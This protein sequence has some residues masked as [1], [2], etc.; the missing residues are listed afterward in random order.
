GG[1]GTRLWPLS[2]GLYPKQFLNLDD[3]SSM[4]E[5]TINRLEGLDVS[6]PLII[7]NEQH[8]FIVAEQLRTLKKLNRNILLEPI[9]KN[10][11]PALALA[12]LYN[13]NFN[14]NSLLLVLA[15]DHVIN[16]NQSFVTSI[17]KAIPYAIEGKLVTFG[18]EP[19]KPETG[20][21]YIKKGNECSSIAIGDGYHVERFVEK[22][23]F[24]SACDYISSGEYLWN[25]GMFLFEPHKYLSELR[26]YQPDIYNACVDAFKYDLIDNDFIRVDP[27]SFSQS[28][29]LSVDYAVMEKT[30]DAVVVPMNAEWSD[31]GSWAALWEISNKD[32][33]GN[34]LHGDVISLSTK[35]SYIYS[36]SELV[37][38]IGIENLAIVQTKDAILVSNL[39]STQDV[40]KLVEILQLNGRTEHY[41]H[42]ER[43]R[44]W[45]KSDTIDTGDSYQVKM[46]TIM[47]RENL[48]MQ[49][50]YKRAEHWVVLSGCAKIVIDGFE[51]ILNENESVHIPV[52][53]KHYLENIGDT[54]L[55]VIEIRSGSYLEEDD[56]IRFSDNDGYV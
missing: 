56:I 21:G 24:S 46:L 40:K 50:H 31:V 12:A 23:N 28:P 30:S 7:C 10:T 41:V 52:G 36:E 1:N 33:D 22:P 17:K 5:K 47:P 8:R 53:V 2:R 16:D 13:I 11:A 9:G 20:Y 18:I 55:R 6:L 44:P 49:V 37:T 51:S 19:T 25:S 3:T 15:A 54:P 29:S 48:S 43:Y 32:D 14:S 42:Q 35:N 26:K 4:L 39:A 27:L 38:T 34:V 45:G